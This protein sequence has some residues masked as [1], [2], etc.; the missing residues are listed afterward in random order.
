MIQKN[1]PPKQ[2]NSQY[3]TSNKLLF[4]KRNPLLSVYIHVFVY[5]YIK[6]QKKMRNN[7]YQ[8]VHS[9][10]WEGVRWEKREGGILFISVFF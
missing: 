5:I 3:N 9:T 7:T 4:M 10:Y 1:P 8:T 6:M 2:W